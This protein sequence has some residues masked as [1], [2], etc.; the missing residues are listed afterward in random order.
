MEE[1][2]IASITELNI[3]SFLE[4]QNKKVIANCIL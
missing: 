1:I 4:V 2:L 3:D